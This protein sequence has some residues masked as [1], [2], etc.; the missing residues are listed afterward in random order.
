M[1]KKLVEDSFQ[2]TLNNIGGNGTQMCWKIDR[3]RRVDTASQ[4][5][6]TQDR[7]LT[8]EI[9]GRDSRCHSTVKY[10]NKDKSGFGYY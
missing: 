3:H 5:L 6:G 9:R 1:P 2:D 8:M 4:S 10:Q 7:H